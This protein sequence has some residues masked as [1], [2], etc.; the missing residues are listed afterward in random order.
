MSHVALRRR[1]VE[2]IGKDFAVLDEWL[3]QHPNLLQRKNA[4]TERAR[5]GGPPATLRRVGGIAL[6]VGLIVM[7]GAAS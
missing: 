1:S 4:R 3:L 6:F 2:Q 7:A 5:H